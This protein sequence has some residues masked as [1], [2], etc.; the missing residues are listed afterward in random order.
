MKHIFHRVLA[1]L[2]FFDNLY[3]A[4]TLLETVRREVRSERLDLAHCLALYPLRNVS[5]CCQIYLALMLAL[6]RYRAIR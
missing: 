1:S 2:V 6:E 5:L 4:L 3:L